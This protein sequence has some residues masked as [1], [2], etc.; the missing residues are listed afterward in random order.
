MTIP[1]ARYS[2]TA[3]VRSIM[4]SVRLAASVLKSAKE[5]LS[6]LKTIKYGSTKPAISAASAAGTVLQFAPQ[7]PS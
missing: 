2:E 3:T 5:P 4:R 7:E 1:T 6:T